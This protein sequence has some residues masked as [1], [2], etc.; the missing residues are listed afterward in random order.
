VRRLKT[1]NKEKIKNKEKT[2]LS[3]RQTY[4]VQQL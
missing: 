3:S 1:K 4:Y 2:K